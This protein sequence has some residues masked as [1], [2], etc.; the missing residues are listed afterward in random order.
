MLVMVAC[1]MR[2][3]GATNKE[4]ADYINSIKLN[5]QHFIIAD[6]LKYLCRGGRVSP[7]SAYLGSMLHIKPIIEFSKRGKLEVTR[8]SMG[9]KNA[10][11]S[12]IDE[13]GKFTLN[14]KYPYVR[15]VHTDNL[16]MAQKIQEM[17]NEKY[18]I[19]PEIRIMGPI[20]GTHVGP[21]AVAFGF[22][23]NQPRA[24]E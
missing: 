12:C 5:I 11:K 4:T 1:D 24:A 19:K 16:P 6:D 2:D 20:I 23:S 17:F 21:N 7:A 15:I 10:I 8:K 13:F 9:M 14:E 3:K 22:I 18:G